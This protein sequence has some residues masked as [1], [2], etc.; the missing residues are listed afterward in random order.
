M[1]QV[2]PSDFSW[3]TSHAGQ[4][5][6]DSPYRRSTDSLQMLNG[7]PARRSTVVSATAA[8]TIR[9]KRR[10]V[11]AVTQPM[12]RAPSGVRPRARITARPTRSR[13]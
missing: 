1:T 3:S 13:A 9:R 7:S 12:K 11:R 4:L 5:C 8:T 2:T 10:R 6:V